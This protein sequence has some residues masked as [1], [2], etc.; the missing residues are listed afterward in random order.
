M[1]VYTIPSALITISGPVPGLKNKSPQVLV[2]ILM[3]AELAAKITASTCGDS[4]LLCKSLQNS[5]QVA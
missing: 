5:P 4:N 3:A 1:Y 2:V